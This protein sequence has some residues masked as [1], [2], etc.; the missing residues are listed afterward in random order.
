M[1]PKPELSKETR[2]AIATLK[3]EG[4]SHRKIRDKLNVSLGAISNTIKRL[5]DTSSFEDR[6]IV[7][8]ILLF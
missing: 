4:Y 5:N 1:A 3:S 8:G 7:Y 2:V 6:P